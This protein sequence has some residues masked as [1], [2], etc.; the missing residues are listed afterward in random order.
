[1]HWLKKK[2]LE[3]APRVT[4]LGLDMKL[5][6]ARITSV[7]IDRD[8]MGTIEITDPKLIE[9]I[10]EGTVGGISIDSTSPYEP[11]N[12]VVNLDEIHMVD[13]IYAD[14]FRDGSYSYQHGPAD[15]SPLTA[16]EL[17]QTED[18]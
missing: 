8:G 14:L 16:E 2:F 5:G 13:P 17:A 10:T 7:S 1:M 9:R 18:D 6:K 3:G 4:N 11:G 12:G 15:M